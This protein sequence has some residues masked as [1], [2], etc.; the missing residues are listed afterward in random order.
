MVARVGGTSGGNVVRPMYG[1]VL[2]DQVAQF[3]AN[4]E[5]TLQ[6]LKAD[7]RHAKKGPA[8]RGDGILEGRE[9]QKVKNAAVRLD[10]AIKALKPVFG[11][12]SFPTDTARGNLRGG[13]VG[14]PIAMYGVVLADDLRKYRNEVSANIDQIKEAISNGQLSGK[15]KTEGQRALKQLAI[16]LKDLTAIPF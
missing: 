15:A 14:S 4:L 13:N 8:I 9:K 1:V 3:R 7:L 11:G 16:A 2:R 6:D 5:V 10:H 12:G